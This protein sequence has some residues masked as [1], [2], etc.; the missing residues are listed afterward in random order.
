LPERFA[1][2]E[3]RLDGMA[4]Q[5]RDLNASIRWMREPAEH[6]MTRAGL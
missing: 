6:A 4:E 1:R 3:V 2:I 5:L